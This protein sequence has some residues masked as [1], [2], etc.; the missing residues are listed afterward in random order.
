MRPERLELEGFTAFRER[1]EIDFADA[2]LFVLVGPTGSGKSSIIDAVIFALY[3]SVPRL[4]KGRVEPVISLGSQRARI[5]FEFSVG[6]TR[7]SATRVV[8]RTRTGATTNEARLEG[9]P[10]VVVGAAELTSAI[11]DLLGLSY[12]HFTKSV[13]LPQGK[14]ASFL[15]DGSSDR[16]ALLRELL[17]LGR[18]ARVR[19][20]AVERARSSEVRAESLAE[21]MARLESVTPQATESL[22]VEVGKLGEALE[23]CAEERLRLIA[24]T[25]QRDEMKRE[26]ARLAKLS[27]SLGDISEPSGLKELDEAMSSALTERETTAQRLTVAG[28]A[29]EEA[30]SAAASA[31]DPGEIARMI[32]LVE[33]QEKLAERIADGT[34]KTSELEA[35]L[36]QAIDEAQKL[37][38]ESDHAQHRLT[39]LRNEHAAHI[40]RS[41]ADAGDPCP[42]CRRTLSADHLSEFEAPGSLDEAESSAAAAAETARTARERHVALETQL[43]QFATQL[44]RLQAEHDE[45]SEGIG[46]HTRVQL[47]ARQTEIAEARRRQEAAAKEVAE[48]R[49]TAD[50]AEKRIGSIT[51]DAARFWSMLDRHRMS[52]TELNPPDVAR[53]DLG[54]EWSAFLAW[55]DVQLSEV[56]SR[57]EDL[58]SK[59]HAKTEEIDA[60]AGAISDRIVAA[61]VELTPGTDPYE[62]ALV[63]R[64][65]AVERLERMRADLESKIEFAAALEGYESDAV[66][67]RSLAGHLKVNGFERW[68]IEEVVHDLVVHANQRLEQLSGGAYALAVDKSEFV[69]ID[70]LNADER[71]APETLSG[72]ETFVVSLSLALSLADQM[73]AISMS[74]TA[75]LESVFLDEGFGTLDSETLD[76]VAAVIHELGA[77][78]RTVGLITHVPELAQQIPVRFEVSKHG[79]GARVKRVEV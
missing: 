60:I 39:E 69:I 56:A 34:R 12:E 25:A 75:R 64:A 31:G 26:G 16:Q 37:A 52:V 10:E 23:W 30:N 59:L 40:L 68:L 46:N 33:Q 36:I 21:S 45:I 70:R 6:D 51:G 72:G 77:D 3:G 73:A 43:E 14:F 71:R 1:V 58:G 42:V 55:R 13:V 29:L 76:T 32:G 19:D 20:L 65:T 38:T 74:G 44:A 7:Y 8:Q 18:Y 47:E 48:A 67:A 27:D 22:E 49:A 54:A 63:A 41:R 35:A 78:G 50:A 66:V 61:G 15:L 5:R 53:K 2:D 57:V 62:Q 79:G 9:G 11:E 28:G 4:R 24:T 17:D